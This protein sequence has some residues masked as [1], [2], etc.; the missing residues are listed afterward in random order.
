MKKLCFDDLTCHPQTSRTESYFPNFF[1]YDFYLLHLGVFAQEEGQ[2][3]QG[4]YD[5]KV[6]YQDKTLVFEF[7]R[8]P[9]KMEKCNCP[10]KTLEQYHKGGYGADGK[11]KANKLFFIWVCFK[12]NTMNRAGILYDR[13]RGSLKGEAKARVKDWKF[14]EF[15]KKLKS[16]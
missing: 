2:T 10:A 5:L 9:K 6:G 11:L 8:H 1:R 3:N 15:D 13:Y 14:I 4:R 7:K 16:K 12:E